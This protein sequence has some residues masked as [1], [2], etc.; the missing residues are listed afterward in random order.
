VL[1]MIDDIEAAW[2]AYSFSKVLTPGVAGDPTDRQLDFTRKLAY[3]CFSRAE[4]NLRILL[5]S[6]D[7]RAA[8]K[9]LIDQ[10]LFDESQV[11]YL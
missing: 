1:V 3:V 9:E 6:K 7:A 4:I 8:G 11:S 10:G 5:F 2:N